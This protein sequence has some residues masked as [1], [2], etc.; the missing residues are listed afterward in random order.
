MR[1][2]ALPEPFSSTL[3]HHRAPEKRR[4]PVIDGPFAQD[5]DG[6]NESQGEVDI[7]YGVGDGVGE[8]PFSERFDEKGEKGC[9]R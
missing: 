1:A 8:E 5:E 3:N 2:R 6:G 4:P 9:R 7:C